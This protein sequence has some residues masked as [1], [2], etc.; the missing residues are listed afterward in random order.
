MGRVF[1]DDLTAF[2]VVV[3][4][5]LFTGFQYQMNGGLSRSFVFPLMILYLLFISQG[6]LFLSGL[7]LLVQ[8][9][10][11]P[12]VFL[13]CLFTHGLIMLVKF[14]P[15]LFAKAFRPFIIFSKLCVLTKL[16]RLSSLINNPIMK[17]VQR[18]IKETLQHP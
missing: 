5:F 3:V 17:G 8:T 10:F 14:G 11:N 2:L 12:Y 7:V 13:L 18:R 9:F 15:D 6:K 16:E 4:Y 1:G